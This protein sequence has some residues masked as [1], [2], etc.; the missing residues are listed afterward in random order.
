MLE[1]HETRGNE[2]GVRPIHPVEDHNQKHSL[3]WEEVQA[4]S[5]G[6]RI[7]KRSTSFAGNDKSVR[8]LR[9]PAHLV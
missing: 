6:I 3:A 2:E 4:Y 9:L 8:R 5:F 7:N 1:L